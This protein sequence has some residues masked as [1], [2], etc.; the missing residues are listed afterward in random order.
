MNRL[1][2]ASAWILMIALT[3][4][5]P[6][7]A[8]GYEWRHTDN[9]APDLPAEA[10]AETRAIALATWGATLIGVGAGIWIALYLLARPGR[11]IWWAF[12]TWKGIS[13]GYAF[14]LTPGCFE[15]YSNLTRRGHPIEELLGVLTLFAWLMM[16][17]AIVFR[18]VTA[19]R[20]PGRESAVKPQ[21]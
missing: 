16:L 1:L 19:H 10:V 5:L 8:L 15:G 18:A 4:V 9:C 12:G 11:I 3:I 21:D 2:A 17:M 14:V 13:L 7:Y 20:K 6:V